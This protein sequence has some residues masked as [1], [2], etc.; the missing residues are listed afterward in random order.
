M[1]ELKEVIEGIP[2]MYFFF[3]EQSNKKIKI[4]PKKLEE[5]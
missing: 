1:V 5:L 3:I 4:S 2:R